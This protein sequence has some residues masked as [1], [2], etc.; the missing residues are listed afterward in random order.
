MKEL[1]RDSW[2]IARKEGIVTI[3]MC[4]EFYLAKDKN[5]AL[6]TLPEFES[7][8]RLFQSYLTGFDNLVDYFDQKFG[9]FILKDKDGVVL[10]YF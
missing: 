4:Y 2:L 7:C 3:E 6:R 1:D 9:I 8:F 10:K 5:G